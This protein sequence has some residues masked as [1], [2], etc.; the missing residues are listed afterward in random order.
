MKIIVGL[1]NP[2]KEYD[3]T[4]HNVGREIAAHIAKK[5]DFEEFEE[6]KKYASL[7][8][9]GE[10]EGE[11]VLILLPNT[12]M[13]KSG[14]AFSELKVKPKD[15]I[16]IHD[17]VDLQLGTLKVSFGKN[18]A[19]HKGVESVMR[20][21]K[22]K[23]FWRI[24]VGVQKK[25]RQDAMKIVLAKFQPQE[26]LLVKKIEKSV[27]QLISSPLTITSISLIS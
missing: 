26:K 21:I 3:G 27:T 23:D 5:F 1:G 7:V 16:L 12:F 15:I 24:R 9:K 8:S 22:T 10:I 17:D 20:A 11:K 19:G 2:G 25:K 6:N 4:R 13:N 18:S 14:K